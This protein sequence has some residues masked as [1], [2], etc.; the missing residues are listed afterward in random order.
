MR[1]VAS[2]NDRV[3]I[4]VYES[5]EEMLS[6][7]SS[8]DANKVPGAHGATTGPARFLGSFAGRRDLNIRMWGEMREVLYQGWPEGEEILK[9]MIED[10]KGEDLP[11]PEDRVRRVNFDENDGDE[12]D[13]DRLRAGQEFWRKSKRESNRGPQTLTIFTDMS[14]PCGEKSE[15]LLWR[16]AAAIAL[17]Y[18][19]EAHG[20]RVELWVTGGSDVLERNKHAISTAIKLKGTSDPLDANSLVAAVSGWFFR[21]AIFREWEVAADGRNIVGGYGCP[22]LLRQTDLD[23]INPD[24]SRLYVAGVYT[25]QDA[26]RVVRDELE[27]FAKKAEGQVD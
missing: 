25:R 9:A 5:N 24:P 3:E 1:K 26:V 20:Y 22:Y 11:E 18:L 15:D 21:T 23:L 4:T 13:F 6:T 12:I 8:T 7:I 14:A 19:L 2:K 27:A 17:T 10:L 16:G